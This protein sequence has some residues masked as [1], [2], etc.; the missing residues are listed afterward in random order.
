MSVLTFMKTKV[1]TNVVHWWGVLSYRKLKVT[2]ENR[3]M[4][5]PLCQHELK[6][7]EYHG[8]EMINTT[9][10]TFGYVRDRWMP[11]KEDGLEVWKIVEE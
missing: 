4:L 8:K 6:E 10:G 1:R 5:C 9:K 2:I 7:A 3:L 11:E